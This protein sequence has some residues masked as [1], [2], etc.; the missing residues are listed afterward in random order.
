MANEKDEEVDT[1]IEESENHN[2]STKTWRKP[3]NI[4]TNAETL[5]QEISKHKHVHATLAKKMRAEEDHDENEV[6]IK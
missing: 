6:S 2:R 5:A 4:I 1:N 3:R